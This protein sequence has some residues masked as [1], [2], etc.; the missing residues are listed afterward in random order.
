VTTARLTVHSETTVFVEPFHPIPIV[1]FALSL[2]SGSAEDPPGK[3]GLSRLTARMLRRGCKGLEARAI[4]DAL[5]SL[6]GEMA[7]D[8]NVSS[9]GVHAQV[10]GRNLDAFVDLIARIV[11]TPTF[12]ADELE[13]LKRETIAEIIEARDSDRSLATKAFH[14]TLF[15][16][17]AY[18]RSVGGT[19]ATVASLTLDDVHA[20][21]ARQFVR[22]N[23]VVGFAGDVTPELAAKLAERLVA[24]LPAGAA[25]PW[26]EP[27]PTGSEG[28]RL[29]F[30]D[31][32]DR[33]QTQ[34]LIGELGTSA[35]DADH[36]AL[37]VANAVFGGTF[38]SR[39]M[40]AVRS[41][42][43]WSY[44]ASAR[45]GLDRKRHAFSMWTFPA[46][47]DAAPCIALE[48]ELLEAFVADGITQAELDFI[49][50]YLVRSH[51]FE[52][53]TAAKRL[54]Q[55]LDIELLALPA[56]FYSGQIARTQA[57]TLESANAA[58]RARL[59]PKNL[60][61]TVVGTAA[62]ILEPVKKAIPALGP[63]VTVAY[64][65]E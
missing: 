14:R 52:I 2:R 1:S 13:R 42:R 17:H 35:H 43:G 45:L 15:K 46:A 32:P 56:D 12:P 50:Q 48:L 10:I 11:S 44:G 8:T 47:A 27:E 55:A 49:T 54:N 30:V 53:D 61:V 62:D 41:E 25:V 58:V 40:R 7:V 36:I 60:L 26:R 37:S 18:G 34:I 20:A 23:V 21:Y 63:T 4:E 19:T 22:G 16:G 28:R 39:L 51:A 5:D 3:E 31:K 65:A 38:T 9:V 64:D 59:H 29:V 6:G 33:T 57:V 24:G